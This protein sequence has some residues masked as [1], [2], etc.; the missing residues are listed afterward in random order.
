MAR[1]VCIFFIAAILACVTFGLDD[2][3]SKNRKKR[4]I[5]T[6]FLVG[7]S[8]NDE[9]DCLNS[10]CC[11]PYGIFGKRCRPDLSDGDYCGKTYIGGN[12]SRVL[13]VGK[14]DVGHFEGMSEPILTGSTGNVLAQ[15]A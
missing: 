1:F 8:C 15:V 3:S 2:E 10:E 6:D 7:K 14:K 12:A 11:T 13:W 4:L 5:I 9:S